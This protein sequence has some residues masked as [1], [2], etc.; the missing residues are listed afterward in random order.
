MDELIEQLEDTTSLPKVHRLA[1]LITATVVGFL[2][3]DAAKKVYVG[4][5]HKVHN[6]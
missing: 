1:M 2:A 6:K 4:V 3:N 5:Y